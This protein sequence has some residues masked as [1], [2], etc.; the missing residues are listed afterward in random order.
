MS[1][2]L[3]ENEIAQEN[4]EEVNNEVAPDQPNIPTATEAVDQGGGQIEHIM[5]LAE[6]D[7]AIKELPEYKNMMEF[8][9]NEVRQ[10]GKAEQESE[11][12]TQEEAQDKK[13]KK[14][15]L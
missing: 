7:P 9:D 11:E 4:N 8:V 13:L 12:E 15:R 1:E 2:E 10:G 6:S 5:R 3:N 14:R